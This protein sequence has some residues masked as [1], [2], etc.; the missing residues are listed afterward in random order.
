MTVPLK[1]TSQISHKLIMCRWSY[2]THLQ[3][4]LS[5]L[6]HAPGMLNFTNPSGQPVQDDDPLIVHKFISQPLFGGGQVILRPG[7]EKGRQFVRND[8][9]VGFKPCVELTLY[10]I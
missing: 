9:M 5:D 8:T 2:V 1:E 10:T 3:I 6:F 4:T 7:A